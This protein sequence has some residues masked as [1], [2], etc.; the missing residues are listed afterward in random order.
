ME[1]T[2]LNSNWSKLATTLSKELF[3]KNNSMPIDSVSVLVPAASAAATR[4]I[5]ATSSSSANTRKHG[6][7]PDQQVQVFGKVPRGALSSGP[8]FQF[9]ASERRRRPMRSADR[10]IALRLLAHRFIPPEH[11]LGSSA[12]RILVTMVPPLAIAN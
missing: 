7:L 8:A 6:A 11:A 9:R 10:R 4:G 3:Y 5:R 12:T 2:R 1:E